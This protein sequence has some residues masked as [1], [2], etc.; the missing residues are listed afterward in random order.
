MISYSV[1]LSGSLGRIGGRGEGSSIVSSSSDAEPE[2]YSES[3]S[4][5][6][7]LDDSADEADSLV[8]VSRML[9]ELRGPFEPAPATLSFF[10]TGSR[11]R[12]QGPVPFSVCFFSFVTKKASLDFFYLV[13]AASLLLISTYVWN[14]LGLWLH[15]Y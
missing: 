15:N 9:V 1:A 10:L 6:E 5:P 2:S 7:S 4:E 14:V 3:S 8:G 12:F 13:I 11:A